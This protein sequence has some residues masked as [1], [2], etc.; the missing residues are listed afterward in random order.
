MPQGTNTS[1]AVRGLSVDKNGGTS[2]CTTE[3]SRRAIVKLGQTPSQEDRS[4]LWLSRWLP[5]VY[6]TVTGFCRANRLMMIGG[7]EL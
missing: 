2:Q 1:T 5:C 3:Q 4:V 6:S 7:S